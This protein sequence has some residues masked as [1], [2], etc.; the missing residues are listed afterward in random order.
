MPSTIGGDVGSTILAR[1][2]SWQ[3]AT[4]AALVDDTSK[5]DPASGKPVFWPQQHLRRAHE[6]MLKSRSTDLL[7]LAR[8]ALQA[9]SRPEPTWSRSYPTI[10]RSPRRR[11]ASSKASPR[12]QA[13]TNVRFCSHC[14]LKSDI[15]ACRR[16]AKLRISDYSEIKIRLK[17]A[18]NAP[19]PNYEPD[20]TKPPTMPM[21]GGDPVVISRCQS[22]CRPFCEALASTGRRTP[23]TANSS[24]LRDF[25]ISIVTCVTVILP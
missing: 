1:W 11:A 17:F 25:C 19:A 20:W 9:A 8:I 10:R 14:G 12:R 13:Q 6:A 22:T 21:L 16:C 4:K 7:V 3:R 2:H 24:G 15:A 23:P 5:N 18:A